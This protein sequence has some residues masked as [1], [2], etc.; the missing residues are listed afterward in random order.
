MPLATNSTEAE[1]F[2]ACTT[3]SHGNGTHTSFLHD[4]WLQ[5]Q[6]PKDLAPTLIKLAWRKNVMVAQA[7]T[8]GKMD[9]RTEKNFNHRADPTVC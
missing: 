1:L 2:R 7:N 4:K 9:A 5:G 8:K 3:I 6:T